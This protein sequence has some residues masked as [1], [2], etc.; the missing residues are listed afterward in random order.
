VVC[1]KRPEG[2]SKAL[3]VF[4]SIPEFPEGASEL[5]KGFRSG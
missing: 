2:M 4:Q 1:L 5:Q 3:E